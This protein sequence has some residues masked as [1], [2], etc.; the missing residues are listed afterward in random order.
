MSK[1]ETEE[2]KEEGEEGR[3]EGGRVKDGLSERL[4]LKWRQLSVCTTSFLSW[5]VM[6]SIKYFCILR[7]TATYSYSGTSLNEYIRYI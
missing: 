6:R 1:K 2:V 4:A 5:S 3:G 7:T